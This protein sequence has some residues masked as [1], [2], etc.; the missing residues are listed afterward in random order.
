MGYADAKT[1]A[2]CREFGDD[3]LSAICEARYAGEDGGDRFSFT[4]V[5]KH[6][7]INVTMYGY[8]D[9]E[10]GFVI[11]DGNWDGTVVESYGPDTS[12][13]VPEGHY[14]RLFDVGPG[15]RANRSLT[16]RT[17]LLTVYVSW[18]RGDGVKDIQKVEHDYAYD[19]HFAPGGKTTEHYD[20]IA[21]SRGLVLGGGWVGGD[22]S[23]PRLD[24]DKDVKPTY[25]KVHPRPETAAQAQAWVDYSTKL[26]AWLLGEGRDGA[27]EVARL[28][29]EGWK[30]R[31]AQFEK[32]M[33]RE[34]IDAAEKAAEASLDAVIAAF[35]AA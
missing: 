31:V 18:I 10:I 20:K 2:F 11:R 29:A 22:E 24:Y 13:V 1:E 25:S 23:P 34:E 28:N 9:N 30:A 14:A 16:Q 8:I 6:D 7:A 35:V 5:V 26:G 3:M 21:R 27:S 19:A 4:D 17:G 32:G 12:T 33:T 15:L